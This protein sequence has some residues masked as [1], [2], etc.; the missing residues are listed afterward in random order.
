MQSESRKDFISDF[1][2]WREASGYT[3]EQVHDA[4]MI[5]EITLRRFESDGLF[6]SPKF[7][8][9]YHMAIVKAVAKCIGLDQMAAREAAM[10]AWGNKYDGRLSRLLNGDNGKEEDQE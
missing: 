2:A 8:Q 7:N 1:K 10:E 9:V 4:T 3:L 6:D 5:S